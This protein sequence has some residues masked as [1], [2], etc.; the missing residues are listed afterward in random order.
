MQHFFLI[1]QLLYVLCV[2]R[3]Y[4][5]STQTLRPDG[6]PRECACFHKGKYGRIQASLEPG[7]LYSQEIA[8]SFLM[9]TFEPIS[10]IDK[11][12]H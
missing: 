9:L 2:A 6:V 10:L 7:L 1:S 3:W 11:L 8:L 5:Q 12:N 4:T